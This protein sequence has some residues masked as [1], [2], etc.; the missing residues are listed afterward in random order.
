MNNI[1][2]FKELSNKDI[3]IAGGKGASLGEMVAAGF[4]IPPGFVVLA[5]AFEKF[6]E[7]TDINIEID[8][9]WDRL[10]VTNTELI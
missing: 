7:E 8:A 10:E 9:M 3:K 5:S 4:P 2:N 1:K 6:I